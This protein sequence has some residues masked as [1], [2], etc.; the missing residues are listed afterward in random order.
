MR[1]SNHRCILLES[2]DP[3][4]LPS[5]SGVAG[6]VELSPPVHADLLKGSEASRSEGVITGSADGFLIGIEMSGGTAFVRPL[7]S[8]RVSSGVSAYMFVRNPQGAVTARVA[9][10]FVDLEKPKGH[11]WAAELTLEAPQADTSYGKTNTL[12]YALR[13]FI[14]AGQPGGF[15]GFGDVIRSGTATL[16]FP[17]GVPA[18]G[19][20][21]VPFRIVLHASE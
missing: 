4:I 14:P 5:S 6:H 13:R 8:L 21:A 17:D 12:D 19:E 20:A 16:R 7:G 10:G 18:S 1:R 3:K 2:L 9:V 11:Q 15:G